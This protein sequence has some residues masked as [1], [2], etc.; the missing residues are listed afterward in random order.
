MTP[1]PESPKPATPPTK[2]DLETALG[3]AA[4]AGEAEYEG[5]DI[6][7]DDAGA[8]RLSLE[9]DRKRKLPT[10]TPPGLGDD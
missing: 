8:S 1:S 6:A 3:A 10:N 2:D 4:E 9:I 7:A 5:G